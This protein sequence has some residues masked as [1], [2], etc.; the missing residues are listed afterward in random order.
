MDLTSNPIFLIMEP[1]E[2]VRLLHIPA[3]WSTERRNWFMIAPPKEKLQFLL[4]EL[5]VL[6]LLVCYRSGCHL[7]IYLGS[8]CKT[9]SQQRTNSCIPTQ[10]EH[11]VDTPSALTGAQ[12]AER[13]RHLRTVQ[14]FFSWCRPTH[15]H[16]VHIGI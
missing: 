14:V 7:C 2:R 13:A 16:W 12:E 4:A 3:S 8:P 10:D 9:A 1:A 11:H 6:T 5:H 15:G